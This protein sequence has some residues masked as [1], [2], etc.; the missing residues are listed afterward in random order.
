M[1][2]SSQHVYTQQYF[3][4]IIFTHVNTYI[5]IFIC[6]YI[7]MSQIIICLYDSL[8]DPVQAKILLKLCRCVSGVYGLQRTWSETW[9]DME[10]G[11]VPSWA[12][13]CG[14]LWKLIRKSWKVDQILEHLEQEKLNRLQPAAAT[15][16]VQCASCACLVSATT[17]DAA[18]GPGRP[19]C[20]AAILV[21]AEIRQP[22]SNNLMVRNFRFATSASKLF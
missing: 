19:I 11:Q 22:E 16:A 12:R 10:S 8:H 20:P 17:G 3:N 18:A 7:H 2:T 1:E 6:H 4:T 13:S 21:G 15:R 9:R 5:H 14:N